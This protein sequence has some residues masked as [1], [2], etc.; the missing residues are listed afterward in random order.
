MI[1]NPIGDTLVLEFVVE[2]QETIDEIMAAVF[3]IGL[4]YG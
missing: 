1:I 2:D 3:D 4:N